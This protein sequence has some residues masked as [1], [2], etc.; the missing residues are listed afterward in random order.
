MQGFGNKI[1]H[2]IQEHTLI[3][4]GSRILIACSGG[5][6]SMVLLH[7]FST[8]RND[9]E[10]DVGA[11]HVDHMLR[12]EESAADGRLVKEFCNNVGIPFYGG[13]VPVPDIIRETGGNVQTVC[14]EGRYAFFD[15]I[16]RKHKYEFLAI[17]HHA[18]DQL[19]TVLMQVTKG[20][21]PLG[22]PIKRRL[23]QGM[24]IRPFL[25]VNKSEIYAYA[26]KLEVPFHEDPSNH[27]ND[28]LR[29]RIRHQVM[30]HMVKEN[31]AVTKSIVPLTDELQKDEALLQQLTKEFV[32]SR[33]EFTKDG[34]PSMNVKAFRDMPTALQRRAIPLLLDYLYDK[35]N[36]AIFYKSDLVYQ[37]LKHLHSYEG[38][39]S[40]DLP[41]G[42]RFIREYDKFSFRPQHV[43]KE[44]LIPLPA[45]EKVNWD[46]HTWLYWG[47][48][49]DTKNDLLI[50]AKEVTFFD[51]PEETL[52]LSVRL[53]K[54][55]DRILMAG[56]TQEKRLSRLF[57][58]EK[59]SRTL[60]DQLP[61]VVTKQD[62]VCAVP[63][64]RYGSVFTKQQKADSKYIFVVG[65]N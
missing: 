15:E 60:R 40:V 20:N 29:N 12:G 35:E 55:G 6:D 50:N 17:A 27:S 64:I 52:P 31:V 54:E 49:A 2:F 63:G 61:I 10:I 43:I 44:K 46:H 51:L 7:F 62:E 56:M 59:V 23:N 33:V 38:N 39:V 22:M 41:F 14:R 21:S 65:N 42:F 57:I 1:R 9:F 13:S 30:P 48:I 5:V 36:R 28:Y 47:K 19:E 53:R 8:N 16:I 3:P 25:A 45:G 58:D 26:K 4:R 37:L 32:D 18:E 34:Y 24:L 11:V